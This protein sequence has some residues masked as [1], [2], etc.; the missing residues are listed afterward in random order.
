MKAGTQKFNLALSQACRG[1]GSG[2][3]ALTNFIPA[4]LISCA[5]PNFDFVR[6]SLPAGGR[7]SRAEKPTAGKGLV[8]RFQLHSPQSE[9]LASTLNRRQRLLRHNP[10]SIADKFYRLRPTCSRSPQHPNLSEH[11]PPITPKNWLNSKNVLVNSLSLLS[12]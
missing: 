9:G 10:V 3:R 8:S 12:S 1:L 4:S 5:S 6:K 11:R 7:A 2:A